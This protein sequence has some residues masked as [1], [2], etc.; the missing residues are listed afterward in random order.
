MQKNILSRTQ[1]S[2]RI[3]KIGTLRESK[4]EDVGIVHSFISNLL[5]EK[6]DKTLLPLRDFID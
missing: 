5:E 6:M 3:S 4:V 2:N 1:I